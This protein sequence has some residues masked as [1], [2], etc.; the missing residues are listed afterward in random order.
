MAA[1]R[2]LQITDLHVF[3]EPQTRLKGIPTR[4]SLERVVEHIV[5]NESNYDHVVV[6]G[7]HTHDELPESY[8]AVR[9]ILDQLD[10]PVWQV[11]GNHDDRRVMRRVFADRIP[12]ADDEPIRF[13][14]LCGEW[15]C[16]GL[17]SH[18]P[19]EVSGRFD[20]SEAAWLRSQLQASDAQRIALF[21]HH[22]P[23]DVDSEWMDVIG[24]QQRE[25][26]QQIVADDDRIRLICC[27]HVH[28][29]F[30][31]SLHQATVCTS[32]STGIQFDPD[33]SVPNFSDE[34]PGYRI[35]E[36]DGDSYQTQVVRLPA[37]GWKPTTE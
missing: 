20:E 11:P 30:V 27:G 10:A 5:R 15:E 33:G 25:L 31:S 14:F 4:E 8:K 12:G 2:I 36:F 19:G 34:P 18:L 1:C 29:E 9:S 23:I 32:P 6:T 24:L 7:D 3:A 26:L 37:T 16:L 13:Q 21:L 17:D 22:P 35:I 28:H